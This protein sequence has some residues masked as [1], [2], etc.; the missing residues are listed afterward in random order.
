[1]ASTAIVGNVPVPRVPS[2]GPPLVPPVET[3]PTIT[4]YINWIRTIM[5]VPIEALP[6]DSPYIPLSYNVSLSFV[7]EY[8]YCA[9]SMLYT[10][11][12]Y[13]LGGDTLCNITQDDPTAPPPYNTYWADLRSSMQINSFTPGLINAANDE[14]TSAAIM[15]PANLQNLT[16]GDMQSLKTPWGRFY[17][18]IAQSVGTLWGLS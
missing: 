5:G 15:T 18:S 9:S 7:N 17:L 2:I 13:N 16:L 4:G 11:A 12:V 1:M 14:D 8:L 6:D 10:L 3:T